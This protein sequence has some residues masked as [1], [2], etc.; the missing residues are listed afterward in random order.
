MARWPSPRWVSGTVGCCQAGTR[1]TFSNLFPRCSNAAQLV[2]ALAALNNPT[3]KLL[4]PA[5]RVL[6]PQLLEGLT[7]GVR[8]VWNVSF[9]S[10]WICWRLAEQDFFEG[11]NSISRNCCDPPPPPAHVLEVSRLLGGWTTARLVCLGLWDGSFASLATRLLQPSS[12]AAMLSCQTKTRQSKKLSVLSQFVPCV[13]IS[14]ASL[15]LHK[16]E[17]EKQG[18]YLRLLLMILLC[19]CRSDSS[20]SWHEFMIKS[21]LLRTFKSMYQR[22]DASSI[23]QPQR[24]F[25]CLDFLF[26]FGPAQPVWSLMLR[27]YDGSHEKQNSSRQPF[28]CRPV[29]PTVPAKKAEMILYFEQRH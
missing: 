15:Y 24:P 3:R 19:E 18:C 4:S 16:I 12:A 7:T 17:G 2:S 10:C 20:W 23:W 5:R 28:T 26:T 27:V 1:C 13:L 22:L 14:I 6:E 8:R 11:V 29:S 25:R 21:N 9:F